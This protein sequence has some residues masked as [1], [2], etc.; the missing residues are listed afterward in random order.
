[1]N[2]RFWL[3]SPEPGKVRMRGSMFK[4]L[5][6]LTRD[7]LESG[8]AASRFARVPTSQL[9]VRSSGEPLRFENSLG[10]RKLTELYPEEGRAVS[11]LSGQITPDRT[12]E[13]R[14]YLLQELEISELTPRNLLP[15]LDRE[16]LE[17]RSD[18]W[19][20][21]LYEFLSGQTAILREGWLRRLPLVRLE[22]GD[23][24]AA[25][26]DEKPQAFL[27]G[28]T[29]TDFP[30]VRGAVCDTEQ[31]REFLEALGLTVPDAVDDVIR[32]ILPRF[33]M[34]EVVPATYASAMDRI[35]R[36]FQTD[37]QTQRSKLVNSLKEVPIVAAVVAG[38]GRKFMKPGDVYLATKRLKGL[39]S[40]IKG[41][42][43]VDDAHECLHGDLVR[44]LL[45]ECGTLGYL[46]PIEDNSLT[47]QEMKTLRKEA[48]YEQTSGVSD[49]VKDCT[50]TGL[51]ELLDLLPELDR[52]D[53]ATRAELL[54]DELSHLE[55]RRGKALFEGHYTWTHDYRRYKQSF[56]AAFLR[57]LEKAAWV[58]HHAGELRRPEL[59]LF[60]SL[61][62]NANAFL[63]SK[64]RFKSPI[65][66]QLAEA[67]GI[68]PGVID[69]LKELKLGSV[70]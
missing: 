51:T 32:N 35:L 11:W 12:P 16:F 42:A 49:R 66:E 9:Q 28:K 61:G 1:M 62:W 58:P 41:I 8:T 53:R 59:V 22:R 48:G 3:P 18:Q 6:S 65:V 34:Q 27:P 13:L 52:R 38:G 15:R 64:I 30:T 7:A 55:D 47:Y 45:L 50:L 31:S 24:V 40:D 67:V 10:R 23:H 70:G 54:W 63:L 60:D 5:F 43:L 20:R 33:A 25:K 56:P 44:K 21:E 26:L 4:P 19:I 46:R 36:A 2:G 57:V 14:H 69:L 37:S 17:R 68:E 29:E 39:F